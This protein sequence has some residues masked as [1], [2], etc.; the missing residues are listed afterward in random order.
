[1]E[2]TK[3]II[4]LKPK[5]T[6]LDTNNNNELNNSPAHP[7]MVI[8]SFYASITASAVLAINLYLQAGKVRY[9]FFS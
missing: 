7:A 8:E 5:K 6:N 3:K 2:T 4:Q 1:M 9:H